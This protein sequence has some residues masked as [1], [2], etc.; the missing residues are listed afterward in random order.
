[1]PDDWNTEGYGGQRPCG[2]DPKCWNVEAVCWGI[3]LAFVAIALGVL[4]IALW[5]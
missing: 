4:A 2:E 5:L 3:A 1:M